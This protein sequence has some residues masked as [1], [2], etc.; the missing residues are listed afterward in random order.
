MEIDPNGLLLRA[1]D[2]RVELPDGQENLTATGAALMS[3]ILL[4]PMFRGTG[5]DKNQR[6]YGDFGS[7]VYVIEEL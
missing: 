1:A 3:G 5:Y 6:T 7:N 4:I 2:R